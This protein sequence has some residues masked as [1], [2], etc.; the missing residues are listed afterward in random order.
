MRHQLLCYFFKVGI[1]ISL[2]NGLA[3]SLRT[4]HLQYCELFRARYMQFITFRPHWTFRIKYDASWMAFS[5]LLSA[6][7]CTAAHR[8]LSYTT[9]IIYHWLALKSR[10]FTIFV[11]PKV[12]T[13]WLNGLTPLLKFGESALTQ[14][15][16]D[17]PWILRIAY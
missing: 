7:K 16:S 9:S 1:S 6:L 11:Q 5:Q 12:T 2:P 15:T 3:L 10:H 8:L 4:S 14:N 17:P 13:A